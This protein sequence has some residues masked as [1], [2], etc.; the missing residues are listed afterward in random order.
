LSAVKALAAHTW[1]WTMLSIC[2]K[3]TSDSDDP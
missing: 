1:T 3:S 2:R